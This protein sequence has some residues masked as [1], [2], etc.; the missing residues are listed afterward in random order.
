MGFDDT[1]N[2]SLQYKVNLVI[3]IATTTGDVF[4]SKFAPDSGLAV[5]PDK[6]GLVSNFTVNPT[7]IDLRKATQTLGSASVAIVDKDAVFSNFLGLPL[8]A[9]IGL[10]ITLYVGFVGESFDFADY[11]IEKQ[12]YLIKT[13][14]KTGNA[15]KLGCRSKS[16]RMI[17]SIYDFRGSLDTAI[18]DSSATVIIDTET[19]TFDGPTGRAKIG[20]EFVAYT[21]KSFTSPLTTLTG[22]SRGDESSTAAAHTV[23][24]ECFF[25]E[26]VTD[27]CI[28]I[29]LQLI[30]STGDGTNGPFDVLFDGIGIAAA[31]VDVTGFTD[32]RDTFF[33]SDDF[34]FL[35]YDIQ[36]ALTYIETELMQ[37]NNLRFT[38]RDGKLSIAIL[39]QS[40]PGAT[41]PIVDEDVILAKPGPSWKLTE[42]RLMNKFRVEYF[43]NE[44]EQVYSKF[45]DFNSTTSQATYGIRKGPTLKF[46]GI[47]TDGIATER[48]NRIMARFS[49][50]QSQID[51]TQ[52]LKTYKTPPGD[53]VNF[54]HTDVPSPGGGLGLNN[55]LELLKRALD[56]SKGT[57]KA[58]YVFTSYVNLRRGL[59]APC[60]NVVSIIDTKT[61]TVGSGRGALYKRNYVFNLY[62]NTTC[63]QVGGVQ[64]NVIDS[65]VG[66][67]ITFKNAWTGLVAGS[68][69]IRFADYDD[70]SGDQTARY[71]YIV[72]PSGLFSDG[73][74]GYKIF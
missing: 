55:E 46:K 34:T 1:V 29:L 61:I 6:I 19:D 38:D 13:L 73:S 22:V 40:V 21:G 50:P 74:G 23:G 9:L 4:F 28:D 14:S 67:V 25:V 20:D 63:L 10:E 44:G 35:F 42:N 31:D 33:A 45:Q 36:N 70:S 26:K 3:K 30:L 52:F 39:D 53:K 17:T 12:D 47:L 2:A 5:D 8:S 72:G 16:D 11:V 24:T 18:T 59:I 71:A 69:K 64:N 68:T 48:G 58:S 32:I 56:Y 60:D 51:V 62:D 65:I 7:Q 27:N 49:T 37:A 43:F 15:Y 54:T 66:D 41:L 57:V